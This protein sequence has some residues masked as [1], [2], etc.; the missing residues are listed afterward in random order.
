MLVIV[1]MKEIHRHMEPEELETYS[2]GNTPP[3]DVA[4]IEEHLLICETCRRHVTEEQNYASAMAEAARRLQQ[5]QPRSGPKWTAI[6]AAAA[7]LF[8]VSGLMLRWTATRQAPVAVDL[9]AV[10]GNIGGPK[11]PAG[12]E[13]ALHPDLTGLT[14]SPSYRMEIVDRDGARVWSGELVPPH[15]TVLAP[16]RAPGTYFVRIY[17][18]VGELLREYGLEIRK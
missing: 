12:R 10:R 4:R 14:A 1:M 18:P 9:V 17:T 2:N 15:Q 8:V 7:C 11:I 5:A 13:L 16:S 6:L 3:A